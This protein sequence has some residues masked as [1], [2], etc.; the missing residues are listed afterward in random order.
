MEKACIKP[1]TLKPQT[2]MLLT[3]L[4]FLCNRLIPIG[5]GR[6]QVVQQTTALADHHQQTTAGAMIL[7]VPLQ[8]LGQAVN[9]LRQQRDLHISRAG[10]LFVHPK[11]LNS[12]GFTNVLST[13]LLYNQSVQS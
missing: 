10:I 2:E 6:M 7:L 1:C 13:H 11:I 9:T 3:Q 4:Q 5:I 12:F 8:V